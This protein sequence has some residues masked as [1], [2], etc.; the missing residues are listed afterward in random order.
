MRLKEEHHSGGTM[1]KHVVTVANAPKIAEWLK[2]RGGIAIWTSIDLGDPGYSV[3]TPALD[4]NGDP[5]TKPR[6]KVASEPARIITDPAEVVVSTDIEVK[7]FHVAVGCT[8]GLSVKVSAGC[9]GRRLVDLPAW[10]QTKILNSARE[11]G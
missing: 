7:R 5:Y 3:T 2:S 1:N 9:A 11:E 6:W 4:A 10:L 8:D